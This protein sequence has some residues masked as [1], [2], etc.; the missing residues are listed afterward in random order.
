[1]REEG[2]GEGR[3]KASGR[4]PWGGGEGR[5]EATGDRAGAARAR[6]RRGTDLVE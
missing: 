2:R 1:M 6:T 3:A 5:S 4:G